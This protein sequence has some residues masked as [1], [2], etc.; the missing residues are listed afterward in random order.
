MACS[1]RLGL[2]LWFSCFSLIHAGNIGICQYA[3]LGLVLVFKQ[4]D[5]EENVGFRN[6]LAL[7]LNSKFATN[8]R[9]LV[10]FFTYES[11]FT[12]AVKLNFLMVS[13]IA[14]AINVSHSGIGNF[15]VF[16]LLR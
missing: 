8:Y 16:S 10:N 9:K 7:G 2:N 11:V 6:I 13:V 3:L 1:L 5:I 4:H 15:F 14:K 12:F